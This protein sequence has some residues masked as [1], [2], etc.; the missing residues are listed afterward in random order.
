[1]MATATELSVEEYLANSYRPDADYVDGHIIERPRPQLPHSIC[2]RELIYIL[3]G[4]K[5]TLGVAVY[6]EQRVQVALRRFRIPDITV[7]KSPA[8]KH[9][10]HLV[11]PP[12]LCIEILSPEDTFTF[13]MERVADY[14]RFGV[15]H[16]W[17]IDPEQKSGWTWTNDGAPAPAVYGLF[18][19]GPI[20]ISLADLD[21]D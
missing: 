13:M 18:E 6:P 12:F 5:K 7:T 4:L 20:R 21:W 16:I 10:T 3:K 1:M 15:E 9:P 14:Q 11:A 8:P 2:Q 19:A 17:V